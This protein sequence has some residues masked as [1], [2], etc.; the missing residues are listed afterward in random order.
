MAITLVPF[1]ALIPDAALLCWNR[2][3]YPSPVDKLLK[4]QV[5]VNVAEETARIDSKLRIS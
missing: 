3:F 2:V 4:L 1:L 5:E